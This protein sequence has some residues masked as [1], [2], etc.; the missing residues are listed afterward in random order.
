MRRRKQNW[1]KVILNPRVSTKIVNSFV[2]GIRN[3]FGSLEKSNITIT[4][5]K[6]KI[7]LAKA[8]W[9]GEYSLPSNF[10]KTPI[11]SKRRTPKSKTSIARNPLLLLSKESFSFMLMLAKFRR[12]YAK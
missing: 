1:A 6:P 7:F 2:S 9:L 5:I 10:M 11:M 12:E 3:F 4:G 8:I